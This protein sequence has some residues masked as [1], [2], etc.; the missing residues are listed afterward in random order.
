MSAVLHRV[1]FRMLTLILHHLLRELRDGRL[2][3]VLRLKDNL[4][5]CIM[6]MQ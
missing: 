4:L 1:L 2:P 3:D 5:V 6:F